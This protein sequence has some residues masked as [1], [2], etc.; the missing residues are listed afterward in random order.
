[1]E[2]EV[3]FQATLGLD[4]AVGI[5]PDCSGLETNDETT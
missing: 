4:D 1:M 2:A 3:A 5:N